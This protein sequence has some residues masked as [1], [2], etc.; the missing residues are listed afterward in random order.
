MFFS[1]ASDRNEVSAVA[2][3]AY[4][5][6]FATIM[7]GCLMFMGVQGAHHTINHPYWHGGITMV[8]ALALLGIAISMTVTC[9]AEKALADPSITYYAYHVCE[10]QVSGAA[11]ALAFLS[12]L[13]QVVVTLLDSFLRLPGHRHGHDNGGGST[14]SLA[15]QSPV[16]SWSRGGSNSSLFTV[17]ED[18]GDESEENSTRGDRILAA[19]RQFA[20]KGQRAPPPAAPAP[21]PAGPVE[22]RQMVPSWPRQK[23]CISTGITVSRSVTA[24]PLHPLPA[25]VPAIATAVSGVGPA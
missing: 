4:M 2:I 14:S 7:Q 1:Q 15:P 17:R 13:R 24:N 23:P 19:K 22:S 16:S 21:L 8:F 5:D 25:T 20:R 10:T 9:S 6:C 12:I 3:I 18:D 11:Y